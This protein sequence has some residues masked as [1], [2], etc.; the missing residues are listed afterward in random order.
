VR[1]LATFIVPR[2]DDDGSPNGFRIKRLKPTLGTV[3]VPTAEVELE[4]ARAWLAGTYGTGGSTV[5][6]PDAQDG[7]GI[8]RMMEMVNGSRFGVAVMGPASI[9]VRSWR[10]RST[11]PPAS[12]GASASTTTR[13]CAR[14]SS[15]CWWSSKPA[16]R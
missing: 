7:R 15:T 13:W 3:G 8:H 1:G 11:P 10:R 14:R 5:E 16:W 2:I 12:S 6:Q 4:G 9:G